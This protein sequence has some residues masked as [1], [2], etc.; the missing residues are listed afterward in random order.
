[1]KKVF[2]LISLLVVISLLFS[3]CDILFSGDGDGGYLP[4]VRTADNLLFTEMCV[5]SSSSGGKTA[6]YLGY[7]A[8]NILGATSYT[9][10]CSLDGT[11]DWQ[12]YLNDGEPVTI[13]GE[14]TLLSVYTNTD[15]KYRF[16]ITGG[17][18]DGQKSNIED[19]TVTTIHTYF[20]SWG[21]DET[22]DNTGVS[23]PNVGYGL[24]ADFSVQSIPAGTPIDTSVLTYQWYRVNPADMEDRTLIEGATSTTYTTTSADKGYLLIIEAKGDETTIGGI[25]RQ[26]SSNIVN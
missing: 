12:N 16:H 14:S 18:Y 22:I 11:T 13:S 1:M 5:Y 23:A 21:L 26:I 10:E 6:V 9:L 25:C 8:P 19:S 17:T 24:S 3:G 20:N 2:S 7:A 15:Y 4:W